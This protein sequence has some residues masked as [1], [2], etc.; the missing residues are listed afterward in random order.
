MYCGGP[1]ASNCFDLVCS[2][3]FADRIGVAA[4]QVKQNF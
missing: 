1:G 2:M 4:L 3:T